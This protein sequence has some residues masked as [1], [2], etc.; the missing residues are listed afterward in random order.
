M[1][2]VNAKTGDLAEI[3]E[4]ERDVF[5]VPWSESGMVFEIE[6]EDA[7]FS[8]A[9]DKGKI[10]GFSILHMFEDEGEIF[11][12]AVRQE[13]RNQKIGTALIKNALYFAKKQR[14][15]RV[16]LEVRESNAPARKLYENCGFKSLGIRKNYYDYPKENAV[17]MVWER[18]GGVKK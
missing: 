17:I 7:L 11:N 2:I 15:S 12:V 4:I 8:L 18:E 10:L 3:M 5:S 9:K 14:L 1:V 13:C 16:F 6:S